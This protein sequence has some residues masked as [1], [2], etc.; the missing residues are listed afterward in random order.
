MWDGQRSGDLTVDRG[1]LWRV[2]GSYRAMVVDGGGQLE[3]RVVGAAWA[4]CGGRDNVGPWPS[5]HVLDTPPP[6]PTTTQTHD[7][8]VNCPL[9]LHRWRLKLI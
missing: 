9:S 4:D 5:E 2:C 1:R 8:T 3:P 7:V 6:G